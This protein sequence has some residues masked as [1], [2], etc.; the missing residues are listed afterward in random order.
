MPNLYTLFPESLHSPHSFRIMY[1]KIVALYLWSWLFL[2]K[3]DF[4]H[5]N[6]LIANMNA[7]LYND[8][9]IFHKKRSLNSTPGLLSRDRCSIRNLI[10]CGGSFFPEFVAVDDIVLVDVN[11]PFL[12]YHSYLLLNIQVQASCNPAHFSCLIICNPSS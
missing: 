6:L 5:N 8:S 3:Y 11:R 9:G 2:L 4:F 12:F 7:V 10:G 1:N